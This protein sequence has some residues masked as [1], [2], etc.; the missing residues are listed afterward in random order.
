MPIRDDE[1]FEKYL[2]QF[3][4]VEPEPLTV[5]EQ[6]KVR[7]RP[8]VFTAWAAAAAIVIALMVSALLHRHAPLVKKA[9]PS[10]PP[11]EEF[12]NP[13]PL[14]IARADALLAKAPSFKAAVDE[15][16]FRPES[17]PI[18]A[19]RYSALALLSKEEVNQ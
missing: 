13:Q 15:M 4:P 9:G 10:M 14:T 8:V 18:S 17:K 16:A 12:N 7:R 3:S 11:V 19:G 5:K 1:Q 2:K 6:L